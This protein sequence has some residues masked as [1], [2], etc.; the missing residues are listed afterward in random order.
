MRKWKSIWVAICL[1]RTWQQIIQM[2][3]RWGC[4]GAKAVTDRVTGAT[5]G[6]SKFRFTNPKA[7]TKIEGKVAGAGRFEDKARGKFECRVEGKVECNK[8]RC[9]KGRKLVSPH[10]GVAVVADGLSGQH[11]K[12]LD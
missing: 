8:V 9:R 7:A 1:I 12:C 6:F 3:R 5:R 2:A 4:K 11:E 10:K